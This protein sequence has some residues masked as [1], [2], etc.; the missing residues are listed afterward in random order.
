MKATHLTDCKVTAYP[1][2]SPNQL[3]V[4]TPF[5]SAQI[6]TALVLN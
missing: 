1:Q 2:I 5:L 4:T 6:C 3:G